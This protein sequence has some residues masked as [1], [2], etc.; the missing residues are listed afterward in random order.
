[1]FARQ[2]QYCFEHKACT[3]TSTLN[4]F[5]INFK[6]VLGSCVN[7]LMCFE[8]LVSV[9]Y[10]KDEVWPN[11][12]RIIV[13]ASAIIM[14]ACLRLGGGGGGGDLPMLETCR[15]GTSVMLSSKVNCTILVLVID[16]APHLHHGTIFPAGKSVL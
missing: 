14:L 13:I 2:C 11:H 16:L 10:I 15:S 4:H 7:I 6:S 5:Q 9:N 1:M 3:C 12:I 8:K